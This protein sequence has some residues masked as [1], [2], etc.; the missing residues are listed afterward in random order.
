MPPFVPT[1]VIYAGLANH[2][3]LAIPKP[4][5]TVWEQVT[6]NERR[7]H[8]IAEGNIWSKTGL[9]ATKVGVSI[10][11]SLHCD[12]DVLDP[13]VLVWSCTLCQLVYFTLSDTPHSPAG[14]K[15]AT[16]LPSSVL[17]YLQSLHVDHARFTLAQCA[18]LAFLTA[19]AIVHLSARLSLGE[20]SAFPLISSNATPRILYVPPSQISPE[21]TAND[22][23][24]PA[25]DPLNPQAAWS[26]RVS[27]RL[28]TNGLYAH[29][30]HPMYLGALLSFIGSGLFYLSK[31][32]IL[33]ISLDNMPF[34]TPQNNVFTPT[35]FAII[36]A[37]AVAFAT[38][39]GL[40]KRAIWEEAALEER[41]GKEYA[42]YRWRVP[43]R[44][45]PGLY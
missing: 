3:G 6:T 37:T 38:I 26:L 30:Q 15:L 22:A 14:T 34:A 42:V 11:S 19:G 7:A 16:W 40:M 17:D 10:V 24:M 20:Y 23:V 44:L 31:G 18:G 2:I 28:I 21:S 8:D 4:F 41:F 29:I 13:K 9:L 39:F 35:G 5:Q 27:H 32:S 25:I 36:F 45:V 33:R 43:Y 1:A 12:S